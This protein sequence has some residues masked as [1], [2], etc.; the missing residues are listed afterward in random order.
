MPL[1]FVALLSLEGGRPAVSSETERPWQ[2]DL[3]VAVS[4]F[5]VLLLAISEISSALRALSGIFIAIGWTAVI[6]GATMYGWRSGR[7]RR[8]WIRFRSALRPPELSV[9]GLPLLFVVLALLV[10]AVALA[11][12]PNNVDS[13]Q[14]HMP[15]VKQWTQ[16][17]S[18]EH[19]PT[20]YDSQNTRPY[21]AELAILHVTLLWGSDRPANLPQAFGMLGVVVAASGIVAVLGGGRRTQWLGAALAFGIPMSILQAT[22]PKNDILSGLWVTIFAFFVVQASKRR[23]TGSERLARTAALSLAVATKGTTLPFLAPLVI[24]HGL[25]LLRSYGFYRAAVVG[26]GIGLAVAAVNAPWWLRNMQTYGGPFGASIPVDFPGGEGA[27]A[28]PSVPLAGL[29]DH[30]SITGSIQGPSISQAIAV[31]PASQII[32]GTRRISNLLRMLAMH[33]VSPFESFNLAY[34]RLLEAFPQLFPARFVASLRGAAWNHAM[35]GGNPVHL[36][37]AILAIGVVGLRGRGQGDRLLPGLA[38]AAAIGYLLVSFAGCANSMFCMRYQIAFFYLTVP[39]TALVISR[40]GRRWVVTVTLA[41][42]VYALPYVLFNNM[43]P[44]IGI[45]PWPTRIESVF[46]AD[47]RVILFAQSP[48]IRDEYEQIATRIRDRG[49]QR[50]GLSTTRFDLEYTIWRLL[51]APESGYRLQHLNASRHTRALLDPAF[52]PCAMICTVCR[53]SIIPENLTLNADYGHVQLY[54]LNQE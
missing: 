29:P 25:T 28:Q 44:V 32:D 15:R 49:C 11:S 39:V 17:Q 51:A 52:E 42:L 45:T 9:F 8:G 34:F 18:L 23:L 38:A 20:S 6:V 43:R 41:M 12:P 5:G 19:F 48:G 27:F 30:P 33:F 54:L 7:L 14:Y 37:L 4:L 50:V 3:L 31:S 26:L 10:F 53:A 40:L 16:N 35:T 47:E 21:W 46:R 13:L 36:V 2:S 24:W 22:T 1:A